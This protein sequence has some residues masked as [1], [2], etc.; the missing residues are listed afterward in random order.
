VLALP[1][2]SFVAD[3][4]ERELF[5][6]LSLPLW[7]VAAEPV[8]VLVSV[9]A[10]RSPPSFF[11]Q[12]AN[13][14]RHAIIKANFFIF[15]SLIVKS[16]TGLKSDSAVLAPNLSPRKTLS[17]R[18]ALLNAPNFCFQTHCSSEPKGQ[19]ASHALHQRFS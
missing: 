8:P 10:P 18:D 3:I 17:Q 7:L 11:A 1:D 6:R 16:D 2:R 13:N 4:D 19:G 15:N 14:P 5:I 9:V 12:P